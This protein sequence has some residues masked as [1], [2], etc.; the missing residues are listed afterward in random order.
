MALATV[1]AVKT[2]A[3]ARGLMIPNPKFQGEHSI[4]LTDSRTSR[5]NQKGTTHGRWIHR[6]ACHQQTPRK[7]PAPEINENRP[8]FGIS[9]CCVCLRTYKRPNF[10]DRHTLAV[11]L[12]H[13]QHRGD[14]PAPG[15][16]AH[17]RPRWISDSRTT[18]P[19]SRGQQN[20]SGSGQSSVK[21]AALAAKVGPKRN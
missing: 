19:K 16:S 11:A 1:L 2:G 7:T 14:S 17:Q 10:I 5:T 4:S 21:A 15:N 8:H 20:S 12:N 18:N 9:E 3:N 6:A 13:L